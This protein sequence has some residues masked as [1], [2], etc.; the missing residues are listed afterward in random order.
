MER[1][2]ADSAT[3][4]LERRQKIKSTMSQSTGLESIDDSTRDR[5][6]TPP[7]P[8]PSPPPPPPHRHH[9]HQQQEQQK[10]KSTNGQLNNRDGDG[11]EHQCLQQHNS[12]AQFQTSVK[13]T[14]A[15]TRT[16]QSNDNAMGSQQEKRRQSSQQASTVR[17]EECSEQKKPTSR[18]A[19]SATQQLH[20]KPL[21]SSSQGISEETSVMSEWWPYHQ[22]FFGR[23][24]D[25]AA[26]E[27]DMAVV[28]YRKSLRDIR[29]IG[30]SSS[31]SGSLCEQGQPAT[32]VGGAATRPLR[33][34]H[35][36]RKLNNACSVL[37]RAILTDPRCVR[38]CQQLPVVDRAQASCFLV[39]VE[40]IQA[41]EEHGNYGNIWVAHRMLLAMHAASLLRTLTGIPEKRHELDTQTVSIQTTLDEVKPFV[42]N[43]IVEMDAR[44][45]KITN[46]SGFPTREEL[47]A[48]M[49]R[50]NLWWASLYAMVGDWRLAEQH[51]A[52]CQRQDN[53]LILADYLR[54]LI[55]T[56]ITHAKATPT[57]FTQWQRYVNRAHDDDYNLTEAFSWLAF[58]IVEDS[59]LGTVEQ[60]SY[61][62]ELS[63]MANARRVTLYST[64]DHSTEI[65]TG[66]NPFI[67]SWVTHK[68]LKQKTLDKLRACS[69]NNCTLR[70]STQATTD[71]E[72]LD[73][74]FAALWNEDQNNAPPAP[75]VTEHGAEQ[76]GDLLLS[77]NQICVGNS[78]HDQRDASIPSEIHIPTLKQARVEAKGH[79]LDK[80]SPL[81]AF[82]PVDQQHVENKREHE[83]DSS[84]K[85]C[86]FFTTSS[87]FRGR[88]SIDSS[89]CY[90][91]S[92]SPSASP[93]T[94]SAT[95]FP[96]WTRNQL[97][98]PP[99]F[100]FCGFNS[101]SLYILTKQRFPYNTTIL[102]L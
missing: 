32:A 80:K 86:F 75:S 98:Q 50:W 82:L 7:F 14:I 65:S 78:T 66:A 55:Y 100:F 73:L 53:G 102:Q 68:A 88:C 39:D 96:T 4:G 91:L 69:P 49:A 51:V 64:P 97:R 2:R 24:D 47:V 76:A 5:R 15:T 6:G 11:G 37:I 85:H 17:D 35:N 23:T 25:P 29:H 28:L 58:L 79:T 22:P 48:T 54:A 99:P 70:C 95:S 83:K 63:N 21:P 33:S 44:K 30:T 41:L 72:W 43:R 31:V 60:A 16:T 61:Y 71:G 12:A 57:L 81:P 77:E 8:P 94:S 74:S 42:N 59:K 90:D 46:S 10:R 18:K 62:L 20:S 1:K 13:T 19:A 27:L 52:M 34:S 67:G 56:R 89:H 87:P 3:C 38:L 40:L 36:Q 84:N 45:D 101:V 92:T 26:L 93:Y 9:H